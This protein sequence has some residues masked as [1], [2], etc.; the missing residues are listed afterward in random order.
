MSLRYLSFWSEV[1]ES[2]LL[3]IYIDIYGVIMS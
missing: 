3:Y 2:H 1:K